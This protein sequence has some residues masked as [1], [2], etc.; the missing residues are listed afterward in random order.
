MELLAAVVEAID[1]MSW[2]VVKDVDIFKP[3]MQE[4]QNNAGIFKDLF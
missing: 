1:E 2:E 3:S 4:V